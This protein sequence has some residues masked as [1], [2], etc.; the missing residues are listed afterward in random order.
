[1]A[2]KALRTYNLEPEVIEL[3]DKYADRNRV[4]KSHVVRDALLTFLASTEK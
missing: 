4:K 2:F 3:L 1:M